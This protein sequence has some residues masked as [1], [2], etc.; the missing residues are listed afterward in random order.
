VI[1]VA[2][3]D[4]EAEV[5]DL[6]ERNISDAFKLLDVNVALYRIQNGID[7]IELHKEKEFN[8]I[9]LDLEMPEMDGLE[10]ARFVRSYDQNTVLIFVTNREDLVFD[11]FQYNAIA[12]IRKKCLHEELIDA[13]K[14]AYN[15][16]ATK[17]SVHLF[18]T[19]FGDIRFQLNEILYFS[20]RGHNVWL[21]SKEGKLYRIFYT[22]EQIENLISNDS[23]IKCHSSVLAN[24]GYIYSIEKENIILTNGETVA[25]SRHRRK[26]VKD[27]LQKYLRS[28]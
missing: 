3:V 20:S 8:I 18:K 2:V 19:E 10:V 23:F 14:R 4:D 7:L 12:F 26:N 22:L 21:H 11:A 28:L 9:F 24:C 25:L 5:L 27:A 1:R 16:V 13:V 15:K 6:L 17:L